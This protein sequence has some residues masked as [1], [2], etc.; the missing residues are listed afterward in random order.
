[1][2]DPNLKKAFSGIDG[3]RGFIY[4]WTG[5][6]RA[7]RGEQEIKRINENNRIDMEVRFENRSKEY[8]KLILQPKR[9]PRIRPVW[10][11]AYRV[12]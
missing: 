9:F 11:G 2:M 7:G 10:V 5:N 12:Q 8:L 6:K 1:M 3:A 4:A